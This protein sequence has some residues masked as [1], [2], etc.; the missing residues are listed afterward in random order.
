MNRPFRLL[1]FLLLA[2][3]VTACTS[4]PEYPG[5]KTNVKIGHTL[6]RTSHES[7]GFISTKE[8]TSGDNAVCVGAWCSCT[9]E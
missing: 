9:T 6:K 5:F 8:T 7:A 3:C 2:A 4:T 1:S